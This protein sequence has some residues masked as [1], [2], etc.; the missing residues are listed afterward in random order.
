MIKEKLYECAKR[1][2]EYAQLCDHECK[3]NMKCSGLK[4]H[5]ATLFEFTGDLSSKGSLFVDSY[6]KLC[7]EV[8][9]TCGDVCKNNPVFEEYKKC[10]KK[11]I[12]LIKKYN[13][14]MEEA[15]SGCYEFS[16]DFYFKKSSENAES[17]K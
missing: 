1:C 2:R 17:F 10:M 14:N 12:D 6:L 11:E 3:G 8:L 9:N 13:R 7:G 4:E 15:T 5:T 16:E